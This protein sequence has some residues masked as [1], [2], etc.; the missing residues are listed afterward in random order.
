MENKA[1]FLSQIAACPAC[2]TRPK[3]NKTEAGY[4]CPNCHR[5][6]PIIDG[7]PHLV[8]NEGLTPSPT[9]KQSS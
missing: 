4:Q 6:Y 2:D 3:L 9:T 7:I 1:D 5:E 8:I